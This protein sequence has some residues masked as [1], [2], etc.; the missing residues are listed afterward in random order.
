[1]TNDHDESSIMHR[2]PPSFVS[3]L[4]SCSFLLSLLLGCTSQSGPPLANV[5]GTVTLDGQPV[6]GA[7]LE[8]IA[9]AGGVAYGKTDASGRYQ[10]SFGASRT[11]A[12]VGKNR[13][14]ITSGDKVTVGDKKYESTEIFPKKYHADSEQFVEVA[15]GSNRLDFKCESGNFQPRQSIS[16][17]GN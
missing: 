1:M 17:G 10:M 9:D 15:P 7:G 13:V 4:T 16:R 12:L 2:L 5:S 6:Q 14:R 8:F 3:F 11:G